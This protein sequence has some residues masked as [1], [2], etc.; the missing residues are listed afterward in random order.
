MLFIASILIGVVFALLTSYTFKNARFLTQSAVTETCLIFSF[1][2]LAYATS[3]ALAFSGIIALLT[4]GILQAHYTWFN[5][6]PQGKHVTSVS[7]ASISYICEAIVFLFIGF[8]VLS[9]RS[10]P[11]SWQFFL[12][13]L[14]IIL[15]GRIFGTVVLVSAFRCCGVRKSLSFKQLWF[16]WYAGLIRGAIAF[17]LVLQI[18]PSMVVEKDVVVTTSLAL[19]VFTT[20]FFGSTMPI[21]NK[22]LLETKEEKEDS[23]KL[24]IQ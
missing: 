7:F 9:F 21:A 6:S 23:K 13:K 17:G 10:F 14:A 8:T 16:I 2:Y 20:C 22:Y 3:Q 18:K 4:C 19:V 12:V 11:W 5:L 1:S 24:K 15:F